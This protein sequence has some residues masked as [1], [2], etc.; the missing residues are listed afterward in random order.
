MILI[1]QRIW[2]HYQ[3]NI[4]INTTSQCVMKF[5]VLLEGTHGRSFQGSRLRVAISFQEHGLS[6]TRGNMIIQSGNSRR[7]IV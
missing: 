2:R 3:V 5:G 6:N 7:D 1:L 4:Q